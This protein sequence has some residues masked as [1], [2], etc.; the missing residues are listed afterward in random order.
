MFI[1][2]G[3]SFENIIT[4]YYVKDKM[5]AIYYTCINIDV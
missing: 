5:I 1:V 2:S 4:L 3:N